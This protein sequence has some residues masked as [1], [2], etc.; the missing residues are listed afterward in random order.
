MAGSTAGAR[1]PYRTSV[2]VDDKVAIALEIEVA[3]TILAVVEGRVAAPYGVRH[4]GCSVRVDDKVAV[5]LEVEAYSV[6][7]ADEGCACWLDIERVTRRPRGV[8]VSFD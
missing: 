4:R 8:R 1:V 2:D 3:I 6:V 5:C 7:E